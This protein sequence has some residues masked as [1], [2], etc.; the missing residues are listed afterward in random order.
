MLPI[1]HEIAHNEESNEG[2]EKDDN[3]I[4]N[5]IL[6]GNCSHKS[7]TNKMRN[8]IVLCFSNH[9]WKTAPHIVKFRHIN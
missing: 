6:F 4:W 2:K 7:N 8:H 5:I 3:K 1:K 9:E